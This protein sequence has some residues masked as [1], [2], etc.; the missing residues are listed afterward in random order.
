MGHNFL[1]IPYSFPGTDYLIVS[2][3]VLRNSKDV[4]R[5]QDRTRTGPTNPHS[6]F[7][8]ISMVK[9]KK[10]QRTRKQEGSYIVK[11]GSRRQGRKQTIFK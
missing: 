5:G 8:I 9:S 2:V 7:F 1:D 10:E 11:Y 6:I 4:C 3:G